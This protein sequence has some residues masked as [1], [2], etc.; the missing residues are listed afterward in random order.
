VLLGVLAARGAEA[1]RTF[2]VSATALVSARARLAQ[3]EALLATP[4][5]QL[6]AEADNLLV[7]KPASVM[8]KTKT[9]ASGDRHDYVSLAPYWW[10]DPAKPDGLPYLRRDG[11]VNPERNVGTDF[12][13]LVRTCKA[14]ETL[15]LA[16]WFT[17]HER[18]AQKAATL[19]RVWFLD[20]AMRMNPNLEHAQA[21]RGINDGR[22]VGI[23]E[24]RHLVG[25]TDGLA[26]LAGS[27]AWPAADA[28]AMTAWLADYYRWLTTSKNGREEAAAENNHGSWYDVQATG[29]ALVLGRTDDAKKLLSAV[30]TKRIA[31]QIEPDGRQPLELTR[32][33]S[34]N[35][36][37]FNLEALFLLSRLGEQVGVDWWNF[38][39]HD[40]RSLRAA[41]RYVAPYADPA[42]AWP[43]KDV[44]AADRA[45]ILPLLAEALRHG[46][47]AQF[48]EVLAKFSGS[49]APGEHWRL[50]WTE[51]P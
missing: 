35:Y 41:L 17:G 34:L 23:I 15:G 13:A 22:G 47:D 39:T 44:E 30:P 25:L 46:D 21:I 40:G 10:P 19:A 20:P 9:A 4:L 11:E 18:Y 31:R 43:K 50:C 29:L 24:A 38:T 12:A 32:T 14:V 5:A 1:P 26:L 2:G 33:K 7:L 27:P 49:P 3:G 51:Q 8:D 37:L 36:S 42:K 45:R 48:R 16:F 28:A 6:R